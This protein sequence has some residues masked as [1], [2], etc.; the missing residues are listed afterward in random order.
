[1]P[2]EPNP[3]QGEP[4]EDDLDAELTEFEAALK[5]HV[6]EAQELPSVDGPALSE[7]PAIPTEEEIEA[8]LSRAIQEAEAY[9]GPVQSEPE[10]E[11]D[12]P[13]LREER[14]SPIQAVH[15]EFEEDLQR[16]SLRAKSAQK[17]HRTASGKEAPKKGLQRDDTRGLAFGF[18]L[19]YGF[20]GPLMAG[21]LAGYLVDR[22]LGLESVWQTWLTVIGLFLG[23]VFVIVMVNRAGADRKG[24]P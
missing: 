20:L 2:E 6:R 3:G 23:F 12:L 8:R 14:E 22:N 13:V 7:P 16:I 9:L 11:L 19:A 24:G 4:L 1:M 18:A 5:R 10:D 21:Y 17:V 15:A